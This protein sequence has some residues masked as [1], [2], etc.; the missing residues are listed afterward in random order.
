MMTEGTGVPERVPEVVQSGEVR[1]GSFGSDR[2]LTRPGRWGRQTLVVPI[3]IGALAG[4][5]LWRPTLDLG[6]YQP[7][8]I[9]LALSAA[10][11]FCR[12]SGIALISAVAMIGAIVGS[13]ALL[14]GADIDLLGMIL[15]GGAAG[16]IELVNLWGKRSRWGFVRGV[17][18]AVL[19]AL[20]YVAVASSNV[21]IDVQSRPGP[22]SGY[23][24]AL[25]ATAVFVPVILFAS[26]ALYAIVRFVV[27]LAATAIANARHGSAHP[28]GS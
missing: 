23:V 11:L 20:I 3:V 1:D 19:A 8:W 22:G 24:D 26:G 14:S 2:I 4:F 15:I 9:V 13:A 28:H 18:G 17:Q 5:I 27:G 6:M 7:A 21:I 16:A 10:Q 25:L 12:V